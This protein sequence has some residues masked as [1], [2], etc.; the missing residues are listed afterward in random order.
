[1]IL[2]TFFR[3]AVAMLIL[4]PQAGAAGDGPVRLSLAVR[5]AALI[6]TMTAAAC[7]A[8]GGVD[9]SRQGAHAIDLVDR[10]DTILT[11]FQDG[12]RY[13]GLEP[14]ADDRHA[15]TLQSARTVWLW[16]APALQ[17][18]VAG[19]L[20]SVVIRQVIYGNNE[21]ITAAEA[22]AS[23][24]ASSDA[25]AGIAPDRLRAFRIAGHQQ[26]LTQRALR[27]ACFLSFGLG[28]ARLADRLRATLQEIETT[29]DRLAHGDSTTPGP[30]NARIARNYRTATLMWGKVAP[31]LHAILAGD[32]VDATAL[33]KAIKLNTSV[34]KQYNQALDGLVS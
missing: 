34:I 26:M 16:Y 33:Q 12:H 21:M 11:A 6:E 2:S 5:Q 4:V 14:L 22:I 29:A 23:E 24:F 17:Q 3:F 32:A 27:Q 10:F 18:I 28:G 31:T 15:A 30:A 1:M 8:M 7:F 19:D 9:R 13:L 20:H 25:G